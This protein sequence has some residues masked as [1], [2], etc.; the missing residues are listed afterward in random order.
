MIEI[1]SHP[2]PMLVGNVKNLLAAAGIA[3]ELHNGYAMGASGGLAC[4]ETWPQLYLLRDSDE[5]RAR[6]V[7]AQ[8]EQQ[9][10][11]W[12]CPACGEE[13]ASAFELCWACGESKPGAG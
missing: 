7:L 12:R 4:N 13:N 2:N 8:Q 9:G 10:R 3:C 11:D 5:P 6:Q 1:Y